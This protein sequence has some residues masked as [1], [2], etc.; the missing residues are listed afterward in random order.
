MSQLPFERLWSNRNGRLADEWDYYE[1][2]VVK[3]AR[4]H[5]SVWRVVSSE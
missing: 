1:K 3:P 5:C 4:V 2:F